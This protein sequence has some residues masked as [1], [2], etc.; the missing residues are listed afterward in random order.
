[1]IFTSDRSET[2]KLISLHCLGQNRKIQV[3]ERLQLFHQS[4]AQTR[5]QFCYLQIQF[6]FTEQFGEWN[7]TQGKSKKGNSEGLWASGASWER[8]TAHS[9]ALQHSIF[10]LPVADL[11]SRCQHQQKICVKPT[12][13]APAVTSIYRGDFNIWKHCIFSPVPF[14]YLLA[15]TRLGPT[16]YVEQNNFFSCFLNNFMQFAGKWKNC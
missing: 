9:S 13:T 7:T 8:G 16:T 11:S 1:M 4:V 12:L 10:L 6:L 14:L 15:R 5:S 3:S 2:N